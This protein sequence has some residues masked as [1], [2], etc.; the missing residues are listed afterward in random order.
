MIELK[1]DTRQLRAAMGRAELTQ[2]RLAEMAGIHPITV[3]NVLRNEIAELGTIAA[4]AN[5]INERLAEAGE[6]EIDP[7]QLL[8]VVALA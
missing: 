1:V 8:K 4:M 6:D 3:G 2:T 5:V 7:L